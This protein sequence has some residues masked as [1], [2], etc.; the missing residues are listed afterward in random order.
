MEIFITL[1]KYNTHRRREE[2]KPPQVVYYLINILPP[3]IIVSN[4]FMRNATY[5]LM[6][7]GTV[8]NLTF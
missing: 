3:L 2:G 7:I 5:L 4:V 6:F 8:Y 1:T